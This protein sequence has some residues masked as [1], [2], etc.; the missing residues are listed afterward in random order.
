[1]TVEARFFS[2]NIAGKLRDGAYD[3]PEGSTVAALMDAA[4]GEA[5]LE[6]PVEQR[7]DFVFVYDNNPAFAETM[8]GDGG[9]LKVLFK[10]T[11]G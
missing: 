11:G 10:I 6:L 8:L 1:M 4:F 9:K 3:L 7:T 5:G 2:S